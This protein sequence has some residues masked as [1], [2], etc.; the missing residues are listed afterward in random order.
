MPKIIC[1][2][3]QK[4]GAGKSTIAFNLAYAFK[5]GLSVAVIDTDLQGSLTSLLLMMNGIKLVGL[6]EKLE[7][8]QSFTEDILII[9]TPPYLSANL[10]N[11]FDVSDF[12]L[13]PTK[14][15]FFDVMAIRAT[16]LLLREAQ[17]RGSKAKSGIVLNMINPRTGLTDQIINLLK[18]HSTPLLAS[19]ITQRVSY[20]RSLINGG[21]VNSKDKK[22]KTEILSLAD[23]ILNIITN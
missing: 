20:V 19:Q 6:P 21:V 17:D 18:E 3:N 1:I 10:I 9:D 23:E 5:N 8:L 22:A 16:I 12:I 14:A 4:G 2:S 11:L 7:E 15:G 13:I